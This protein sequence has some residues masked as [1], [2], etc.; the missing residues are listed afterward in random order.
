MHS[1]GQRDTVADVS[2]VSNTAPRQAG[3]LVVGCGRLDEASDAMGV[4]IGPDGAMLEDV[5]FGG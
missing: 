2:N 3:D 5:G 1:A 4:V